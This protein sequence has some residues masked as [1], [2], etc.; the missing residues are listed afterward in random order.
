[1]K[2]KNLI[3]FTTFFPLVSGLLSLSA[4]N[5]FGA[6]DFAGEPRR[7]GPSQDDI[8]EQRRAEEQRRLQ[9]FYAKRGP[10]YESTPQFENYKVRLTQKSGFGLFI[11]S[12][13]QYS[14]VIFACGGNGTLLTLNAI[15]NT[16]P[17]ASLIPATIAK[18][19]DPDNYSFVENL[20]GNIVGGGIAGPGMVLFGGLD[21]NNPDVL[22]EQWLTGAAHA[23]VTAYSTTVFFKH[24]LLDDP[25]SACQK[26]VSRLLAVRAERHRR[27]GVAKRSQGLEDSIATTQVAGGDSNEE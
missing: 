22:T 27:D 18:A 3:L 19:T 13:K 8:D 23:A 2:S 24:R 20:D 16:V 10:A 25:N 21:A 12:Q 5:A 7:S 6:R 9:E 11:E 15:M 1:M 26:A 4:P 14:A 17:I